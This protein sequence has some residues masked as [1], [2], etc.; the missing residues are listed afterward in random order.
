MRL[1]LAQAERS[2]PRGEIP[3][4]CVLV[5]GDEVISAARNERFSSGS[6]LAH[7]EMQALSA[8]QN[9]LAQLRGRC[10]AFVTL[11]PCMMCMG[12]MVAS[13]IKR[14]VFAATDK[15]AGATSMLDCKPHYVM[16]KP[17]IVGGVL[18]VESIALLRTY[19]ESS[20]ATWGNEYF[21][22]E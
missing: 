18:A 20:G 8:A 13:R 16:F 19:V 4:G 11:E 21:S 1:A 15:L 17:E 10:E 3:V 5:F 14:I 22:L 6:K 7:A 2:L 9:R 12:A